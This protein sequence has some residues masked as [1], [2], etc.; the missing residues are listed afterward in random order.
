MQAIDDD[1]DDDDSKFLDWG[2]TCLHGR[3]DFAIFGANFAIT[4]VHKGIFWKGNT[5][6]WYEAKVRGEMTISAPCTSLRFL[7][8]STRCRSSSRPSALTFPPR[9]G[10]CQQQQRLRCPK[11]LKCFCSQRQY[12]QDFE[13]LFS[14]LNRAT[15]KR[16]PGSV[17][18]ATFLV[19]GTTVSMAERTLG[20]FGVQ[21]AWY[22]N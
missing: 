19:T 16:E 4:K 17:T 3:D 18:S 11:P 5:A 22:A 2:A 6:H 14:N 9:L 12:S 21:I 15:L 1:D 20:K 13:R 10:H 7:H 8:L